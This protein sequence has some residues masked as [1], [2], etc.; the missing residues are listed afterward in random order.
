MIQIN[1][2]GIYDYTDGAIWPYFLGGP[3]ARQQLFLCPSD[4]PERFASLDAEETQPDPR[5]PRNFTYSFN[6]HLAGARTT[7]LVTAA[8]GKRG[9]GWTGVK[10]AQILHPTEKI[11]VVEARYPRFSDQ[12][13]VAGNPK[14]T[15]PLILELLSERHL[16]RS[17]QCFADGHVELFDG[18]I[19]ATIPADQL[20]TTLPR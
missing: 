10:L 3:S 2:M 12:T 14:A 13:I 17:N 7:T 4:G 5:F 18:K 1:G 16:G 9:P 6:D 8:D 15:G 19:L 11:L 20:Y